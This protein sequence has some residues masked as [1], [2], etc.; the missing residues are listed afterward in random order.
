MHLY[1]NTILAGQRGGDDARSGI[2][3]CVQGR[4]EAFGRAVQGA[5]AILLVD[6][7][8]RDGVLQSGK[9]VRTQSPCGTRVGVESS[10]GIITGKVR[11]R[12][13]LPV[14]G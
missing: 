5:C 4:V 9:G 1:T 3:M 7:L 10:P 14:C 2:G 12:S 6:L 11:G 8:Q 13:S